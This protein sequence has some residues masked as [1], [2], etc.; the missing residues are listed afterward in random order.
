MY[1]WGNNSYVKMHS[2]K[3]KYACWAAILLLDFETPIAI[4]GSG[5]TRMCVLNVFHFF[6]VHQT[7]SLKGSDVLS[8]SKDECTIDPVD[9]IELRLIFQ[10]LCIPSMIH[11]ISPAILTCRT[12]TKILKPAPGETLFLTWKLDVV[13]LLAGSG[14]Y[15]RSWR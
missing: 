4:R 7:M 3:C 12:T 9:K 11:G 14:V 2:T 6:Y 5:M 1:T 10:N 15:L 13:A 8:M